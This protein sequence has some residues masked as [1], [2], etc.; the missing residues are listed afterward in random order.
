[1]CERM[2]GIRAAGPGRR[3]RARQTS[4]GR[5]PLPNWS[6]YYTLTLK[7]RYDYFPSAKRFVL[8]M[9][10]AVHELFIVRVV[11]EIVH[12]LRSITSRQ[13]PSAEF[14]RDIEPRGSTTIKFDSSE[15]GKHDP[16][17]EIGHSKARNPGVVIEVPYSQKKEGLSASCG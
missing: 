7:H 8:R 4:V 10:S 6:S 1:M 14:A 16:D 2:R 9:P 12:Q 11:A 17:A 13:G 3:L 15:Y 5:P